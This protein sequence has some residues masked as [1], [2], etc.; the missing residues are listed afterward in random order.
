M[1]SCRHFVPDD[2]GLARRGIRIAPGATRAQ[3]LRMVMARGCGYIA[4]GLVVGTAAALSLTQ[5]MRTLLFGIDGADTATFAGVSVVLAVVAGLA[6]LIRAV[7]ATG[8]GFRH[9]ATTE[10]LCC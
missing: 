8:V 1:P 2:P 6:I 3:I 5:F 9:F 7:R 10:C 4:A